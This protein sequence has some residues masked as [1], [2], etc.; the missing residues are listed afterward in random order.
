MNRKAVQT[1]FRR[2]L[3]DTHVEVRAEAGK[4]R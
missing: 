1:Q 3:V 4:R 2:I